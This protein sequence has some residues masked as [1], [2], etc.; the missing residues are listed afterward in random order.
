MPHLAIRYRASELAQF[1]PTAPIPQGTSTVP[2]AS[3]V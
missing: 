3:E 1:R 2:F